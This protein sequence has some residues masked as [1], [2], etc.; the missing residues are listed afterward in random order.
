MDAS[1]PFRLPNIRLFLA[2]RVFFHARFYYPIFT[3][4]FRDF[5]LTLEQFAILNAVW[6]ATIVCAEVP[7]GAL[8]DRWGRRKL[9]YIAGVLMVLEM[10]LLCFTPQGASPALFWIFLVNRVLSGAAEAA[11]SGADE[12][13]AY[14][15]L[16]ERG[17]ADAWPR[18]LVGLMRLQSLAFV[19]AMSLGA[20][21]YDPAL[22][23]RVGAWFGWARE[24]TQADTLHLPLFLNLLTAIL[25]LLAARAMREPPLETT[26]S[27]GET[28]ANAWRQTL[29]TGAWILRSPLP[30]VLIFAGVLYDSIVRL[31][32]TL[33]SE[34]YRL[35]DIPEAW[36]GVIGS[37]VA[38]L[39]LLL[40]WVAHR[41]VERFS[42]GTNALL[43]AAWIT[44]SLFGLSLAIPHTGLVF[45]ATAM[46][47]MQFIGFFLSHYLNRVVDSRRRATVLSFKGLS[48]NL[49]YG[50][51]SLIYGGYHPMDE[52]RTR[53][54][55]HPSLRMGARLVRTLFSIHLPP[56][57]CGGPPARKSPTRP[58][59]RF[60][61]LA[62]ISHEPQDGS[63]RKRLQSGE[64]DLRL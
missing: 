49:A 34:Y 52:K 20:A 8:A 26:P 18:V 5:G 31:F 35:I 21:I 24:W 51:L 22:V 37:V 33:T 7:S 62:R 48:N 64:P 40:P 56:P 17:M 54:D 16:V 10:A 59:P 32:A 19:V 14:D 42:M 23:G 30:F 41:M 11:A 39:G 6:A 63:F 43:L 27:T 53:G 55:R 57:A 50:G 4:L 9:V 45:A 13:L 29:Q 25:A 46:V 1:S 36:Y 15:S 44:V 12:A 38:L 2:F 61:P 47:S 28:P 58:H 60:R 3:I